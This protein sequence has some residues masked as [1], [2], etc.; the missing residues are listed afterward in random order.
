MTTSLFGL[1]RRDIQIDVERVK[2][3]YSDSSIAIHFLFFSKM[4]EYSPGVKMEEHSEDIFSVFNDMAIATGGL[5]ISSSNP[6]YLFKIASEAF[7]NYYLLYYTP[8]NYRI[9]FKFKNIKVKVKG[10]NYRITHRI[11]YIAD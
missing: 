4:A 6:E 7:E 2:Q 10:K 11:G 8:K 3:A 5:T 9:D 1:Y